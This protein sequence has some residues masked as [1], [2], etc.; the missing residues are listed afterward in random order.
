MNMCVSHTIQQKF[1]KSYTC[2]I[3][4]LHKDAVTIAAA[5]ADVPRKLIEINWF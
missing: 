4:A 1:H 5:S 3:H 2:N